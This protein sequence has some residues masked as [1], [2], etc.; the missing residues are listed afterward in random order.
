MLWNSI[1]DVFRFS[2]EL[3]AFPRIVSKYTILSEISRLFDPLGLIGPVIVISKMIVQE[4]W[5]L[6]IDWD[7]TIPVDI[8]AR[9]ST[10]RNQLGE[11]NNLKI[12]CCARSIIIIKI[13][14]CMDFE[15]LANNHT[16]HAYIFEV[17]YLMRNFMLSFCMQLESLLLKLLR[18][19]KLRF[20]QRYC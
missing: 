6:K 12:P 14:N 16:A 11:L 13:F 15:M 19:R 10:F 3:Q 1:I 17:K 8:Y 9:W 7:T 18:S 5:Q 4:I 2:V 20:V